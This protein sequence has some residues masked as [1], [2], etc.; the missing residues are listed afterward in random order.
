M[1]LWV[2]P[3]WGY[4]PIYPHGTTWAASDEVAQLARKVH[5][6]LQTARRTVRNK[7]RI[8]DGQGNLSQ[9]G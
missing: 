4:K 9:L 3:L 8:L 7:Q 5:A 2:A 6:D 1:T